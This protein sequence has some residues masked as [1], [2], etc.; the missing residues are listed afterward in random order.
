[1]RTELCH[2]L[3]VTPELRVKCV[4]SKGISLSPG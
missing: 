2:V 1:M 4:H 3:G